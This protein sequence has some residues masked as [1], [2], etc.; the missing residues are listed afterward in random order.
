MQ[1]WSQHCTLHY[2]TL[3]TAR[4]TSGRRTRP[5]TQSRYGCSVRP[6]PL[7]H[8]SGRGTPC[9]STDQ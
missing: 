6:G 3:T 4:V 7:P 5:R 1:P 8:H 9:R 2:V